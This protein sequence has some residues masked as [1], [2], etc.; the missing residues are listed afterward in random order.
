MLI[1]H[2]RYKS[3]QGY[4]WTP[5]HAKNGLKQHNKLFFYGFPKVTTK[6]YHGYYWIRKM[7]KNRPKQHTKALF[8]GR[9]AKKASAEGQSPPQELELGPRRGPYL[10]VQA[11]HGGLSRTGPNI[12][13]FSAATFPLLLFPVSKE[14]AVSFLRSLGS[15]WSLDCLR[16]LEV[17]LPVCPSVNSQY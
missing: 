6:S 10:L 9:R 7:A 14:S 2:K 17:C 8:F 15:R 13:G 12:L 4:Y 3:Y 1:K 11:K 5:K 16:G